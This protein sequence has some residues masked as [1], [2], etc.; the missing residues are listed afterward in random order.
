MQ[1]GDFTFDDA[2]T[3]L[4][5]SNTLVTLRMTGEDI[6]LVLEDAFNFFL[7]PEIGGSSG[8]F[9]AAAGLRWDVDYTADF[10]SRVSNL[11][12][13]VRLR[14]D[15]E[16]L[17]LAATFTV[18]TNNFIAAP[19][20]GYYQFGVVREADSSVYVDTFVEYAQSLI[21]YVQFVEVLSEPAYD[22]FSTQRLTDLDGNVTDICVLDDTCED[23]VDDKGGDDGGV[24]GGSSASSCSLGIGTIVLCL[25]YAFF[26]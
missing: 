11:E 14:G 7:D 20:D 1:E 5:F 21:K 24:I 23:D 6:R 2:I 4:P 15:W 16:P 9:P 19:R 22:E 26:L 8:A 18:V 13:N 3:I 25:L 17:D 12:M 10:G